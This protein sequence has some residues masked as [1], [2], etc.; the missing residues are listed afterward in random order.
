MRMMDLTTGNMGLTKPTTYTQDEK[1][2]LVLKK[3]F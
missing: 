2:Q 1:K 3:K